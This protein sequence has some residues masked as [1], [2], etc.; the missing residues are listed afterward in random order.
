MQH[1]T[2]QPVCLI[3]LFMKLVSLFYQYFLSVAR[4]GF[5]LDLL[6]TPPIF[7]GPTALRIYFTSGLGLV[8]ED[9][10]AQCLRVKSISLQSFLQWGV[11]L[12]KLML[13]PK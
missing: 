9:R 3:I 4:K 2:C 12:V 8:Y 6:C 5:L 1:Y 13:W 7:S 11:F 10:E